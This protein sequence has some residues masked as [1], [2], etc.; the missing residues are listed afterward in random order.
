M[1]E[2]VLNLEQQNSSISITYD[3]NFGPHDDI[4]LLEI[5]DKLL[6]HVLNNRV[7]IRG[8]VEEDAVLCTPSTTY[9]LKFVGT[10]NSVFLIPPFG[11][12]EASVASVIKVAPGVMELV[13][14]APKLEKLKMLLKE[15]QYNGNEDFMEMGESCEIGLYRWDDLVERVQASDVELR[16]GLR[17]FSAVEINGYW[18][19]VEE[20][21][22]GMVLNMLLHNSV[23][24]GW[25]L[26]G[27]VENEVVGVLESDGFLREI[28]RLCLEMYGDKVE[29]EVGGGYVWKLNE[30]RVCVHFARSVL[31]EGKMKMESFMEKWMQKIPSGMSVSFEM[32]EGEVL[33]EKLGIETWIRSFSVSSLP[34]TPAERFAALFRER[35][36][37]ESMD[38]EPYIRDLRVPGLS[39][40]G[41]L[42]KYTRR[43]QPTA[44]AEPIFSAR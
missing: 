11:D 34:L 41:L 35:Q 40:E 21:F 25:S 27:L 2:A 43:T 42:L 28:A 10:T 26:D 8:N 16:E 39:A 29:D 33:L 7:T 20:S 36:K 9:A 15:N 1:A 22:M 31:N 19:V 13:E 12:V 14:V 3:T 6:P 23:L 18:R 30:K 32:L 37:W 4:I 17:A 5:D 38:L 24:S 44:D